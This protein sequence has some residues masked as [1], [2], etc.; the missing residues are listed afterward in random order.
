MLKFPLRLTYSA[1]VLIFGVVAKEVEMYRSISGKLPSFSLAFCGERLDLV[2]HAKWFNSDRLLA[3][4]K[5]SINV[6]IDWQK[7]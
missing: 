7:S 4:N 5:C 6:L 2:K 1:M 3:R